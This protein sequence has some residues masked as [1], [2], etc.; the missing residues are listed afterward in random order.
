MVLEAKAQVAH[1]EWLAWIERNFELSASK[2]Q[3]YMKLA[4]S[5]P[6]ARFSSLRKATRP[7]AESGAAWH[8]SVR[9][10]LARVNIGA[11]RG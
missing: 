7:N 6:A 11:L 3:Q 9:E 4:E 2:A 10:T 8:G 5:G 1:G